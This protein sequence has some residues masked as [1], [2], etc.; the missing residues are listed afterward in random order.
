MTTICPLDSTAR[1]LEIFYIFFLNT[2]KL[3]TTPLLDLKFWDNCVC[4]PI[5]AILRGYQEHRSILKDL[6]PVFACG[7]WV[8]C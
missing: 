6:I 3:L 1:D 2:V 5:L 8:T 7:H 4:K